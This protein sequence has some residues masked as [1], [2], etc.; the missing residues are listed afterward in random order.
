MGF[1]SSYIFPHFLDWTLNHPAVH[2]ER[3]VALAKA[4]GQTLEIGFG[5]GLN[6]PSYPETVTRLVALDSEAMLPNRVA[7]RI[8]QA[9]IPVEQIQFD[10]TRPLPF[11]DSTFDTVVTTFTLCSVS[12]VS[13]A[14]AELKRVLKDGGRYLFLEHGL[15]SNPA[16]ARWQNRLNPIQRVVACGCNLNRGI[17]DLITR[18]GFRA[19]WLDRFVLPG[20]PEI[21]GTSYR[22]G[23]RKG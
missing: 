21:L 7:E 3:R 14:L 11:E 1:Y 17:D 15:S 10:A 2:R 13:S 22:G 4:E 12:D 20:V 8:R 6:L 5:T 18:A 19:E 16:I 9:R 23:A